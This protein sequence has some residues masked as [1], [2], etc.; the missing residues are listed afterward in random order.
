MRRSALAVLGVAAVVGL[1]TLALASPAQATEPTAETK[2][3]EVTITDRDDTGFG[4]PTVWAKDTFKR[5]VTVVGGPNYFLE[6]E[7]GEV[8]PY[9]GTQSVIDTGANVCDLV[10]VVQLLWKYTATVEDDGTFV[11]TNDSATGSPGFGVA[12]TKDAKGTINGGATAT[13]Y[14][15]AHWCSWTGDEWNKTTK[16]GAETGSTGEFLA[17][18]FGGD[19]FE[20]E[21]TLDKWAWTYERCA[22]TSAAEKWVNTEGKAKGESGDITGKTPCPT[23]ATS[24]SSATSSAPPAA[25]ALPVTG[26]PAAG[27]AIG[28]VL[29][30]VVGAGLLLAGRIRRRFTA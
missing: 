28:G 29:L 11:T 3:V 27:I 8:E 2:S 16:P 25:G 4:T 7:Q 14:A 26:V 19:D 22:G 23:P 10:S 13:I 15:P 24:T 18:L 30:A 12:L 17:K 6:T 1:T 5:K 20:A 21:V 9:V